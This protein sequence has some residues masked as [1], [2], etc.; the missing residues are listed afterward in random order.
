MIV[1]MFMISFVLAIAESARA[2]V[3]AGPPRLS[4]KFNMLYS[5]YD[6]NSKR[7]RKLFSEA[8]GNLC[9]KWLNAA[10]PPPRSGGLAPDYRHIPPLAQPHLNPADYIPLFTE[11]LK[12]RPWLTDHGH[13]LGITLPVGGMKGGLLNREIDVS[14]VTINGRSYVALTI[15]RDPNE[16]D[17]SVPCFAN[18]MTPWLK[19]YH[20]TSGYSI[21]VIL[22]YGLMASDDP[23]LGH[24]LLEDKPGC[25]STPVFSTAR[26]YACPHRMFGS[27]Q[28]CR[29]VVE[30][31]TD[32]NRRNDVKKG[33]KDNIQWI[34]PERSTRVERIL[35][36]TNSGA[37]ASDH[38]YLTFEAALE[39]FPVIQG[40][41]RPDPILCFRD[42][43]SEAESAGL[44]SMS[45]P[46]IKCPICGHSFLILDRDPQYLICTECEYS[47]KMAPIAVITATL[48]GRM[49][50]TD[51][52]GA[53]TSVQS[54]QD[55]VK[56]EGSVK[57]E[58]KSECKSES[59][60]PPWQKD[61][62]VKPVPSCSTGAR[63]RDA[64][65][66]APS[67]GAMVLSQVRPVRP[68]FETRIQRR[69][70]V[71]NDDTRSRW[72]VDLGGSRW[73]GATSWP[74][75]NSS[76]SDFHDCHQPILSDAHQA[77]LRNTGP[78]QLTLKHKKET[79]G[80]DLDRMTQRNLST[81]TV[82]DIRFGPKDPPIKLQYHD[83]PTL[84]YRQINNE[85][86]W[87]RTRGSRSAREEPDDTEVDQL[88]K[89]LTTPS[90]LAKNLTTQPYNTLTCHNVCREINCSGQCKLPNAHSGSC[91]CMQHF[92]VF[93]ALDAFAA[94]D[95]RA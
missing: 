83:D 18:S 20:G 61:R 29:F 33:R 56:S 63:R 50:A 5:A 14:C 53:D 17:L 71:H 6:P 89:N 69:S 45:I 92:R 3:V 37:S 52:Y 80:I 78:P 2:V 24:H 76:W 10:I 7:T 34:N 94:G 8:R 81:E 22:G 48:R 75:H 21:A 25:Y 28:F 51:P 55:S 46:Q 23:E 13:Q 40:I 72:Q 82:R 84:V 58:C 91:N 43:N 95:E 36:E 35:V 62:Q 42:Y 79:W 85:P 12:Q 66:H 44:A 70:S 73:S 4:A 88:A 47:R 11:F 60:V 57:T 1:R 59:P 87:K 9:H 49:R 27:G 90:Q 86:A 64:V 68:G 93:D 74:D 39:A 54:D 77:F 31:L 19:A 41:H 16:P 67:V 26:G 15:I 32:P 65:T 30:L 38:R